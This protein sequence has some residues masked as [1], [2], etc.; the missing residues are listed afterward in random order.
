MRDMLDNNNKNI[1]DLDSIKCGECGMTVY[2]DTPQDKAA[3]AA[4]HDTCADCWDV[5]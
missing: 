3:A 4:G 1:D 5:K 2:L